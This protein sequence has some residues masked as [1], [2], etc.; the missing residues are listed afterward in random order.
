MVNSKGGFLVDEGNKAD[1]DLRRKEKER[2]HQRN[3]HNLDMPMFLDPALNPKCRECQSMD[4]DPTFLKVFKCSVCKTCQNAKPEKYSLLTKTECKTDYL[5]TDPELRDEEVMPHLL[6]ANPH[7]STYANM[8]L[9]L[10]F[11]VEEFAWKKWGS[12]EALDVEYER[13]TEEKKKNKN[14]KFEQSLKDLRKRTKESI[15]QKRKDEEHQHQFGPTEGIKNGVGKQGPTWK[16]SLLCT[17]LQQRFVV[18]LNSSTFIMEEG[19][20]QVEHEHISTSL[21]VEQ[22]EV[23]LFRSKSL[24]L[25]LRARGVFGGQVISQALVSATSC[26][27]SEFA[28]H[29]L[30]CYF[31]TSASPS[32]P[33]VYSVERLREGRSYV[34]RSVKAVQNGHIIFIMLC[35]FQK[36]EPW[37]PTH[38]W[39][40]PDVPAPEQCED[41]EVAYMRVI[42]D[43]KTHP[44]MVQFFQDQLTERARSP[45]AIKSAK[46]QQEAEGGRIVR[47]SYWMKARDIPVYEAPFQKCILSYASD[48]HFISTASRIMGLRRGGKG[49]ESLAMLSTLDHSIW[50]Y[51]RVL[52]VLS[53]KFASLTYYPFSNDFHAGDWL[54]YEI[55]CPRAASGRAIVHGRMYTRDGKL[56]AVTS[57]EGV[58]RANIKEPALQQAPETNAQPKL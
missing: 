18:L 30:H 29:S 35:S 9:F 4:I 28:L 27:R 12:P 10:R 33:I 49:A 11:Q 51:R 43:P 15:W 48:M 16:L 24:W 44:A 8:M 26:V 5:L 37:Q 32:T 42:Q 19:L 47:Y 23:N 3:V 21:E 22:I 40:M 53:Y 39:S 7:K 54:L 46:G 58:V 25:P 34:T 50:F 52:Q 14:K 55:D 1:E 31:L 17:Q 36:P 20:N 6:K 41:E 2:E 57:Q 45:I 13:R 38:Q 56:V